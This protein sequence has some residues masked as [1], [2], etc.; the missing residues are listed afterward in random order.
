VEAIR[1]ELPHGG[2]PAPGQRELAAYSVL[3]VADARRW[4]ASQ[5][6]TLVA[7][8]HRGRRL[9]L[10]V[11]VLNLRRLLDGY[12]AVERVTTFN[13]A[14]NEHLLAINIALGFRPA[15]YDGEW[16]R[17]VATAGE[18]AGNDAGRASGGTRTNRR[19]VPMERRREP[20]Y[21]GG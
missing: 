1:P 21:A 10:L 4:N 2:S 7:A 12:P 14:E 9:G 6:D 3:Q 11:R 20:A 8:R 18:P 19:T 13:A 5:E 17:T 15:G 16:Q